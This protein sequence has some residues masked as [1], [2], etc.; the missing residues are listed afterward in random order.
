MSHLSRRCIFEQNKC[1][2]HSKS[3]QFY[4]RYFHALLDLICYSESSEMGLISHKQPINQHPESI[5]EYALHD[6]THCVCIYLQCT[7]HKILH[8]WILVYA[9]D[10]IYALE[11]ITTW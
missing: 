7:T 2:T 4:Q 1:T 11:S 9:C 6:A 8:E 10:A 3:N 5:S